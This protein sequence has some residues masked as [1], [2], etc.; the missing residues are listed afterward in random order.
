MDVIGETIT[1]V[2]KKKDVHRLY[3]TEFY[4]IGMK[5]SFYRRWQRSMTMDNLE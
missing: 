4:S 3:Q 2:F 5:G 1:M